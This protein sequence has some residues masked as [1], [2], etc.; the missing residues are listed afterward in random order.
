MRLELQ[1][2]TFSFDPARATPG[3]G[4]ALGV[5]R[6]DG[7]AAGVPD[8]A[9]GWGAPPPLAVADTFPDVAPLPPGGLW[10]HSDLTRTDQRWFLQLNDRDVILIGEASVG[11]VDGGPLTIDALTLAIR[12]VARGTRRPG[13]HARLAGTAR[14]ARAVGP[15][16]VDGLGGD[17]AIDL[18]LGALPDVERVFADPATVLD[19]GFVGHLTLTIR[20]GTTPVVVLPG[21]ALRDGT[22]VLD[23]RVTCA[24]GTR[25]LDLDDVHLGLA[26]EVG[27][28]GARLTEARLTAVVRGWSRTASG[29]V[30]IDGHARLALPAQV[31][32]HVMPSPLGVR[33]SVVQ[34]AL[35]DRIELAASGL[36]L[37][38]AVNVLAVDASRLRLAFVRPTGV[39]DWELAIDGEVTQSWARVAARLGTARLAQADEDAGLPDVRARFALSLPLPAG[40]TASAPVHLTLALAFV[41]D[42]VDFVGR[43]GR[44]P[45]EVA[46]VELTLMARFDQGT[47]RDPSIACRG[48]ASATRDLAAV[49]PFRDVQMGA[50][51]TRRGSEAPTLVLTASNLPALVL[52]PLVRGGDA[53]SVVAIRELRFDLNEALTV[54]GTVALFPGVSAATLRSRLGLPVAF[55]G[56][57]EPIGRLLTGTGR[58]EITIDPRGDRGR[59]AVTYELDDAPHVDPFAALRVVYPGSG[60]DRPSVESP[61]LD[62]QPRSVSLATSF[63]DDITP[64]IEIGGAYACALL[65]ETF[66]ARFA[67]RVNGASLELAMAIGVDDPVRLTFTGPDPFG[68]RPTHLIVDDLGR[69]YT[70]SPGDRTSLQQVLERLAAFFAQPGMREAATFELSRVELAFRPADASRPIEVSGVIRPVRLPGFVQQTLPATPSVRIG[71]TARSVFFELEVLPP[72]SGLPVPLFSVPVGDGHVDLV[73]HGF[74]VG[75][76]WDVNAIDLSLAADLNVVD[77][78]TFAPQLGTGLRLPSPRPSAPSVASTFSLRTIASA[79][80]APVPEWAVTFGD[81]ADPVNVGAELIVGVPG[82]RFMTLRV[83]RTS[84]SITRTPFGLGADLDAGFVFGTPPPA[85]APVPR[86]AFYLQGRCV[87]GTFITLPVYVGAL[88]NPLAIIPPFLSPAPPYWVIP[89]LMMGDV[90]F[91]RLDLTL[92][93][94]QLLFGTVALE[95]PMPTLSIAALAELA[96]LASQGFAVP[97]AD[98]SPLFT[99]FFVRLTGALKVPL[100]PAL[101]GTSQGSARLVDLAA[102]D[103]EVNAADALKVLTELVGAARRML[104][105]AQDGLERL[106]DDPALLIRLVPRSKRQLA[107]NLALAVTN[108]RLSI[109][110]SAYL[111][112]PEELREELVLYHENK[113]PAGV[114]TARM[115]RTAPPGPLGPIRDLQLENL[116]NRNFDTAVWRNPR[117]AFDRAGAAFTRF[118]QAKVDQADANARARVA[119]MMRAKLGPRLRAV[120]DERIVNGH[121]P[122]LHEIIATA[123]GDRQARQRLME[124]AGFSHAAGEL[125][126]LY[127]IYVRRP[128]R[129]AATRLGEALRDYLIEHVPLSAREP[130]ADGT[131]VDVTRAILD[132]VLIDRP[133][134]PGRPATF[135]IAQPSDRQRALNLR[136]ARAEQQTIRHAIE[137]EATAAQTRL[138]RQPP[139]TDD[140]RRRF[141][142]E[143]EGRISKAVTRDGSRFDPLP[144]GQ[145]LPSRFGALALRAHLD[146]AFVDGGVRSAASR[147]SR[148]FDLQRGRLWL[149]GIGSWRP[150]GSATPGTIREVTGYKVVPR[151]DGRFAGAAFAMDVPGPSVTLRVRFRGGR[152]LLIASSSSGVEVAQANL[153]TAMTAGLAPRPGVSAELRREFT[154]VEAE[155]RRQPTASE[156]AARDAAPTEQASHL[157]QQ[158]LF[159]RAEYVIKETG[160]R[161][162]ALTLGDVLRDP[163]TGAYIV[164]NG[165]VLIAGARVRLFTNV[166]IG[167]AGLIAPPAGSTGPGLFL[168]GHHD[169]RLDLPLGYELRLEGDFHVVTGDL[170]PARLADPAITRNSVSFEGLATL[171]RNGQTVFRGSARGD[172]RYPDASR[173]PQFSIAVAVHLNE[174]WEAEVLDTQLTKAWVDAEADLAVAFDGSAL[175]IS[176]TGSLTIRWQIATFATKTVELP[177]VE[178]C[179]PNPI[180]FLPG[181]PDWLCETIGGGTMQVPDPTR[182]VWGDSHSA[183]A[184]VSARLDTNSKVAITLTVESD[185]ALGITLTL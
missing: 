97:L 107:F 79:P 95:K 9:L 68:G 170:W 174:S 40:G 140:E 165:P 159:A 128:D 92:N 64:T 114:G 65:E 118:K 171:E 147:L 120:L 24:P 83:R 74:R 86:P 15:I 176:A 166:D 45:I 13:V 127:A 20:S 175:S 180:G 55:D 96:Y 98:D 71:A 152:Y 43:L 44:L 11:A 84:F 108:F 52:P 37:A 87:N 26:G 158:S 184:E 142:K 148:V 141:R 90:F 6:H 25:R 178:L 119:Q 131:L 132:E 177:A 58:I 116:F 4:G 103:L 23:A 106:R 160:G 29:S 154:I 33:V 41:R 1:S 181:E 34:D 76:A 102:L 88:L 50:V 54:R 18:D 36:R 2:L 78:P 117:D 99:V 100:P 19:G 157:Y 10:F 113:R 80:P 130:I 173:P 31:S 124:E 30:A 134:G 53:I 123:T 51:L 46:G 16:A 57:V 17:V 162:G 133:A 101:F 129:A 56:L 172:F 164:P 104:D 137:A 143:L 182:L 169:V 109:S 179:A 136:F 91:E 69:R 7:T 81:A 185:A 111:L 112:T 138:Q 5:R 73:L 161:R 156:R 39:P 150:P 27:V 21:V 3:V 110:A 94:P 153:P 63:G 42:G 125:E 49:F 149:D 144:P 48:R 93:I 72:P 122:L 145:P 22:L 75:Y 12:I 77:V 139:R 168:R 151:P 115:R 155:R 105:T 82:Q 47:F 121:R 167:M 66:D 14:C 59:L 89:G 85:G 163:A 32:N 61:V 183:T 8:F 38:P 62:L 146:G 67:L 135:A 28:A 35:G 60:G 70:L 126:R